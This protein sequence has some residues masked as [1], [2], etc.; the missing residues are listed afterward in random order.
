MGTNE[1]GVARV[2]RVADA[3][4]AATD[5]LAYEPTLQRH[6]VFCEAADILRRVEPIVIARGSS[7]SRARLRLN[8]EFLNFWIGCDEEDIRRAF[9]AGRMDMRQRVLLHARGN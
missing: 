5:H 3:L 4:L 1:R 2:R 6:T 8:L 9:G 7:T